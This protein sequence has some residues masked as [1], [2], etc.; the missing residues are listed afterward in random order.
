[1]EGHCSASIGT[2]ILSLT[3]SITLAAVEGPISKKRSAEDCDA[4]TV[5]V[6]RRRLKGP[7]SRG[8]L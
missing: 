5:L 4:Q 6:F 1:M 8:I 3:L 2:E 7:T